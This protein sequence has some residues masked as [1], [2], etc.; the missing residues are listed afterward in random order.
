MPKKNVVIHLID[1]D[2]WTI[3]IS[4]AVLY[5]EKALILNEKI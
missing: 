2:N 4:G 5:Y 1:P 3:R